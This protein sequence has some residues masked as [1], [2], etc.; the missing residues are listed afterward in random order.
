MAMGVLLF[1]KRAFGRLTHGGEGAAHA[2]RFRDMDR[3]AFGRRCVPSRLAEDERERLSRLLSSRLAER[4]EPRPPEE[5]VRFGARDVEELIAAYGLLRLD[6]HRH[7]QA[8]AEHLL[9]QAFEAMPA[10][11]GPFRAAA[12]ASADQAAIA[13]AIRLKIVER[14]LRARLPA[15][16]P[17]RWYQWVMP[18]FG[19]MIW[20][21]VAVLTTMAAFFSV[22]TVTDRELDEILAPPRTVK[23][24]C[25]DAPTLISDQLARCTIGKR[26][27]AIVPTLDVGSRGGLS[28][29]SLPARSVSSHEVVGDLR[30]LSSDRAVRDQVHAPPFAENGHW[31]Y[32][33]F[34]EVKSPAAYWFWFVVL[35]LSDALLVGAWVSWA[36]GLRR[37]ALQ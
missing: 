36:R 16:P 33:L 26:T 32:E 1:V 8:A 10:D 4:G 13:D 11:G 18:L 12:P 3:L 25:D 31:P 30:R 14:D 22:T 15:D 5:V 37:P 7:A 20:S 9:A 35:V 19:L 27:L 24:V 28:R 21:L 17:R 6:P 23:V 29:S 2:K 34:L